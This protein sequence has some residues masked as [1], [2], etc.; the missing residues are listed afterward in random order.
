MGFPVSPSLHVLGV[1]KWPP[2]FCTCT[3][4]NRTSSQPQ[5]SLTLGQNIFYMMR[6]HLPSGGNV[7]G[8]NLRNDQHYYQLIW[9][10]NDLAD[11][12]VGSGGS[13]VK[14]LHT[15]T[16]VTGDASWILSQED[17][18]KEEMTTHSS[19][20]AWKIPWT[21]GAWWATVHRVA[22]NQTWLNEHEHKTHM[23]TGHLK[24]G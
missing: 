15:N 23:S 13:V 10:W 11:T 7:P 24:C 2:N 17:P 5:K 8:E 6:F 16:G 19:I 22:E 14:N 20:L 4:N 21:R 9:F 18:L 3:L 12:H 1:Y